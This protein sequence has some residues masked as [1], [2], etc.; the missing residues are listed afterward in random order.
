MTFEHLIRSARVD[1][2]ETVREIE[3]RS[4]QRFVGTDLAALADDE[5][6]DAAT[7]ALRIGAG[8]LLICEGEGGEPV[9][10][11][12]LRPVDGCG[13]VEQ[14]D[15]LPSHE[16]RGI[17]AA[18][19]DRVGR[20]WPALLLSTFR[21][22]PWNAPYY[23]RLGFRPVEGLTPALLAIRAEHEARGLDESRRLFMRRH[24]P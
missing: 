22:V 5:P 9:A 3:R 12:M 2:I 21:E 23:A 8:G 6:T 13:Y 19:L 16:R 17:G 24:R 4:A 10:F 14:I 20:D 18:L 11:L 15:V 7:L 1:E